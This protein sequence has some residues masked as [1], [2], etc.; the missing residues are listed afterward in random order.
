M[1]LGWLFGVGRADEVLSTKKKVK[2]GDLLPVAKVPIKLIDENIP[3]EALG[4]IYFTDA[5]WR[6]RDLVENIEATRTV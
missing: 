5:S 6:A 3:V 2:K 1:V 4:R